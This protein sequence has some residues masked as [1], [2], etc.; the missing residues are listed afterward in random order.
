MNRHDTLPL[1]NNINDCSNETACFPPPCLSFKHPTACQ[2]VRMDKGVKAFE[3]KEDDVCN[4]EGGKIR[5]RNQYSA[6]FFI[7][8]ISA[9]K[10]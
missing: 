3:G 10:Q 5:T 1:D 9:L 6:L 4:K 2:N 8:I 7:V